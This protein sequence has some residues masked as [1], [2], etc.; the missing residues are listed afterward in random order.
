MVDTGIEHG[1]YVPSRYY[2]GALL[3]LEQDVQHN[4]A[5]TR[6]VKMGRISVTSGQEL[7]EAIDARTLSSI[8]RHLHAVPYQPGA[9]GY[10][11]TAT[12]YIEAA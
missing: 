1:P 10:P 5:I 8:D 9:D 3:Q 2:D 12:E 7:F 6:A 11:S 4:R